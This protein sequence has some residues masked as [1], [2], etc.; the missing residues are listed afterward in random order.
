MREESTRSWE[1]CVNVFF[2]ARV[3]AHAKECGLPQGPRPVVPD[4]SRLPAAACSSQHCQIEREIRP[5]LATLTQ[6]GGATQPPDH[7]GPN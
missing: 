2:H 6:T 7:Q 3:H 1:I 4:W 5:N